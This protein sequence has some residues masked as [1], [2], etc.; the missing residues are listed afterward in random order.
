LLPGVLTLAPTKW[1]IST[2][3]LAIHSLFVASLAVCTH[4]RASDFKQAGWQFP[5]K[6]DANQ[7]REAA[8]RAYAE[9][10]IDDPAN[11]A[12]SRIWLFHGDKD[13]G[14]PTSTVQELR[15]FYEL[16]GV[17]VGN[18]EFD[19]GPDAEHGMPVKSTAFRQIYKSLQPSRPLF[20]NQMRL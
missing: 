4:F 1:T 19:G 6:A 7:S 11:L 17:P 13:R 12:N 9:G 18:I 16:M 14:V 2:H 10:T 5:H 8:I 15:K 20:S 3:R